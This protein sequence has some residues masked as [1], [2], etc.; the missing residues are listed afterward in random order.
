MSDPIDTIR[1][2]KLIAV[3]LSLEPWLL[4]DND[5]SRSQLSKFLGSLVATVHE[6]GTIAIGVLRPWMKLGGRLH[7]ESGSFHIIPFWAENCVYIVLGG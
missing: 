5:A 4:N 1:P 2:P 6:L 7:G 3:D